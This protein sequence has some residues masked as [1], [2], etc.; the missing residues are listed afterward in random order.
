M[1]LIAKSNFTF[2]ELLRYAV[3]LENGGTFYTMMV[4]GA[5]G[6]VAYPLP[7]TASGAAVEVGVFNGA[8]QMP[9]GDAAARAIYTQIANSVPQGSAI[10]GKVGIDQTT[11]GTTNGVQLVGNSVPEFVVLIAQTGSGS[12]ASGASYDYSSQ[13]LSLYTAVSV[14]VVVDA[15][16]TWQCQ[17][18]EH[19]N[20]GD[21]NN[22]SWLTLIASASQGS[23]PANRVVLRM[24]A[25]HVRVTNGDTVSHT[26]NL[27]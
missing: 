26:Y 24:P 6:G 27:T 2:E 14:F 4:G 3:Q 23:M 22:R 9:A 21:S 18:A 25:G 15:A 20:Y 7:L 16:H 12:V 13:D 10:I 1:A 17:L 5:N 8:N 11:P 19:L